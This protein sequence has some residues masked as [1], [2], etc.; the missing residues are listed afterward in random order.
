MAEQ[1][2]DLPRMKTRSLTNS[3]IVPKE[4]GS[5]TPLQPSHRHGRFIAQAN[6]PRI[7]MDASSSQSSTQSPMSTIPSEV[8]TFGTPDVEHLN[9]N[10][11][12]S[13]ASKVDHRPEIWTE[14]DSSVSSVD[15][16]DVKA[17]LQPQDHKPTKLHRKGQRGEPK[18]RMPDGRSLPPRCSRKLT[19]KADP[20]FE[21]TTV[22]PAAEP[23]AESSHAAVATMPASRAT[24]TAH[25]NA[26]PNVPS[27]QAE[28][29][30]RVRALFEATLTTA[31]RIINILLTA[32]EKLVA[33]NLFGHIM[34]LM[35]VLGAVWLAFWQVSSVGAAMVDVGVRGWNML[36]TTSI[37]VF[38]TAIYAG[39]RGVESFVAGS[40]WIVDPD[41]AR[42]LLRQATVST[43]GG[44]A[45]CASSITL[46]I[47]T[48]LHISCLAL[49]VHIVS[50][51][52]N[53][54]VAELDGWSHISEI[55]LPHTHYFRV[56]TTPLYVKRAHLRHNK[57]Q[58]TDKDVLIDLLG[59]YVDGLEESADCLYEITLKTD[60]L[61]M[62]LVYNLED[63]QLLVHEVAM[64]S[65]YWWF[66]GNSQTYD[67]VAKILQRLIDMFDGEI[68]RILNATVPCIDRLRKAHDLGL[69]CDA[70][71]ELC[72]GFVSEQLGSRRGY[73]FFRKPDQS[74]ISLQKLVQGFIQ[75]DTQNI[76]DKLSYS[77]D[78]LNEHRVK[79]KSTK[80]T[81]SLSYA[82]LDATGLQQLLKVLHDSLGRL[83]TSKQRLASATARERAEYERQSQEGFF[84]LPPKFSTLPSV[85][86]A[87]TN[88][89]SSG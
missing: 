69:N 33:N 51:T 45:L 70:Y 30:A 46:W 88:T 43:L 56:A 86:P 34:L 22:A 39:A 2:D 12:R 79:L 25:P 17:Q 62:V 18:S 60:H 38:E 29:N 87:S 58:L 41:G 61:L 3:D 36:E 31:G 19:P 8:D 75:Q 73:H 26:E 13:R 40:R 1:T 65:R 77:R 57:V 23:N 14:S 82:L 84:T 32:A 24:G 48:W 74:L 89:D 55:L 20:D 27:G 21:P 72:R 78:R 44:R 52:L 7:D 4:R 35:V 15:S 66:T 53:E 10:A 6:D 47:A 64:R 28:N 68:E 83:S 11:S 16:L 49:D 59:D 54:T 76:L 5:A 80:A 9:F 63:V 67:R 71:A 85:T 81:I 42:G 50:G 37:A